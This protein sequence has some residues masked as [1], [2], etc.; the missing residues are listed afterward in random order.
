MDFDKTY[1]K[2]DDDKSVNGVWHPLST[3]FEV[4]VA[5]ANNPRFQEMTK[6][7]MRPH[8][9]AAQRGTLAD[10]LIAQLVSK[11]MARTILLDWK[12]SATF[13]GKPVGAYSHER[14][15]ELLVTFQG[16]REDIARI[17]D[18][19]KV[20]SDDGLEAELGNSSSTSAGSSSGAVS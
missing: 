19:P 18:D 11:V 13:A 12:G 10:D 3:T 4:R 14:A 20:F 6:R 15:E 17:A 16:F 1:P 8:R 5:R 2:S 7:V 9:V